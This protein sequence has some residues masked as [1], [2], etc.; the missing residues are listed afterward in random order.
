MSCILAHVVLRSFFCAIAIVP[1]AFLQ[2]ILLG[3]PGTWE[4]R[5]AQLFEATFVVEALVLAAAS[6]LSRI[7]SFYSVQ[8]QKSSEQAL[9][10]LDT[11]V[12]YNRCATVVQCHSICIS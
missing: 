6:L 7:A 4:A 8:W 3:I 2:P 5:N 9:V 10:D 12:R 11:Q 1:V